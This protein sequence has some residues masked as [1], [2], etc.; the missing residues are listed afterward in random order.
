VADL[1]LGLD[2]DA[3]VDPASVL[4]RV[5]GPDRERFLAL[6][7][8]AR[9]C[10]SAADDNPA[11]LYWAG[12]VGLRGEDPGT[13]WRVG[14]ELYCGSEDEQAE[15]NPQQAGQESSRRSWSPLFRQRSPLP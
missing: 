7:D 4:A 1:D 5:P 15:Q 2:R 10:Y 6:L 14:A 3:P 13:R 9:I 8:D 11:H 12:G